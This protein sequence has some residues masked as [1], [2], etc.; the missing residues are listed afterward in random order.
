MNI[1]AKNTD[2]FHKSDLMTTRMKTII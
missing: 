2:C 1:E